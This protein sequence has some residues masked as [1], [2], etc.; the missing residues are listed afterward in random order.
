MGMFKMEAFDSVKSCFEHL[1]KE[2]G[3][4]S[5]N[6]YYRT[7]ATVPVTPMDFIKQTTSLALS[8]IPKGFENEPIFLCTDDTIIPKEGEKFDCVKKIFDHAAHK[9]NT[10]VNGHN[11]VSLMLSVPISTY[12]EGYPMQ[13][14]YIP[15][16]LGY[17]MKTDDNTKLELV[18]DMVDSIMEL[19]SN[20]QI[21]FSFDCWFAKKPFIT[22]LQKYDNIGIICNARIDS[23]IY[24]PPPT[25]N[26]PHRGRP[27]KHGVQLDTSSDSDFSFDRKEDKFS[28]AHRSVI[29]KIFNMKEVHAYVTKTASDSRRLFLCTINPC[30]IHMGC[31]WQEDFFL[32]NIGS[33]DMEWYPLKLYRFRWNIEVS[34]YEQKTFWSLGKYMVRSQHS[35]E[36]LLNLINIAYAVT[37]ILPHSN[38][39]FEQFKDSSPQEIRRFIGDNINQEL[40]LRRIGKKAIRLKNTNQ[41]LQC[42]YGLVY[43]LAYVS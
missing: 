32:R 40:F 37:R 3:N 21:I 1:L 20:K 39:V 43:E 25:I 29:A 22:R 28:V 2:T 5:L 8:L 26:K 19:M 11:F 23:A 7:L 16:P 31:A 17:K 24:E 10:F 9:G 30:D 14:R 12:K 38:Q 42:L 36:I 34:Y 41:F 13:I 15:I 33:K 27:K 6:A 4:K 35:I 18:A